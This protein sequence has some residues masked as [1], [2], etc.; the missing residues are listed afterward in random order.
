MMGKIENMNEEYAL[1]KLPDG[2]TI[3]MKKENLPTNA[4]KGQEIEII[5]QIPLSME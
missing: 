1:V 3:N 2:R 4:N 5:E